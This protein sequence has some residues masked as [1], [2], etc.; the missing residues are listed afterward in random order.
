MKSLVHAVV[1]LLVLQLSGFLSL[2]AQPILIQ[3]NDPFGRAPVGSGIENLRVSQQSADGTEALLTMDYTY[4]GFS[5]PIALLLPVIG[6]R[7]ERGVAAWFGADPITVGRGR[8][9]VSIKVKY[10]NDEPGVPP[11]FTSDQVQIMILNQSATVRLF[12]VPFLKNIKWGS[13]S[14]K[15][16]V[17]PRSS[18]PAVSI[19]DAERAKTIAAEKAKAEEQARMEAEA[20]EKAR[21]MAEAA[22]Q[23]LAEEKRAVEHKALGE[24]KAREQL[25]ER[26]RQ[27]ALAQAKAELEAKKLAEEK[28]AE[29]LAASTAAPSKEKAPAMKTKITNVDVVNR[30]MD[31]TQ[32]TFG[33]EFE[34]KDQLSEPF[35]GVDVLRQADPQA[36]RYFLSRPVALGKSRRNFALFPVK[37]Q[38]PSGLADAGS[39][40]TDKVVVYLQ[41]KQSARRYNIFPATMLLMWRA[42]GSGVPPQSALNGNSVEMV[43]FKQ[44]DASHGYLSIKYHLL[45]GRGELRAKV[46]D[47]SNPESANF[48]ETT[49]PE[50]KPGRGLQLIEV[51]VPADSKSP[52]DILSADTIEIELLDEKGTVLAKVT[53]NAAMV[54]SK[55][56]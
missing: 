44:N 10:F 37:F 7:G 15:P 32:M 21:L 5:G 52:A 17:Q 29:A 35:V 11:M 4:D 42:A 33:V 12:A 39:F 27:E 56:K 1:W 41:E 14:A 13:A 51:R 28:Q 36:S 3:P 50:V 16:G 31:R 19:I 26:A 18:V 2:L 24:A 25:E 55:P 6:K 53:K 46:Y 48:F 34:Y 23:R 9:T 8:G 38:P 20:R 22:A 30:S 49:R 40:S 43:D 47:A 45:E 54:W